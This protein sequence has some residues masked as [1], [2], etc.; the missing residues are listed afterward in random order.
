MINH[1]LFLVYINDL[2]NFSNCFKFNCMQITP[3]PIAIVIINSEDK[4]WVLYSELHRL[5]SCL[6]MLKLA[7]T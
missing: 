6:N 5:Y 3:H 4:E 2:P 1:L 7:V